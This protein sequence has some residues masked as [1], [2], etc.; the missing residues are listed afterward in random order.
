MA[1]EIEKAIDHLERAGGPQGANRAWI[2]RDSDFDPLREHP[3]FVALLERLRQE[4]KGA[5]G[6]VES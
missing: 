2:E 6:V 3:R 1:G 4:E 5:G